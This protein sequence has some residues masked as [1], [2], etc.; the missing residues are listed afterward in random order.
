M[1]LSMQKMVVEGDK[2]PRGYGIAWVDHLTYRIICLPF[3]VN[4]IARRIRAW[5]HRVRNVYITDGEKALMEARRIRKRTD[6]DIANMFDI[7]S[8]KVYAVAFK[9]GQESS[10]DQLSKL[11]IEGRT[12]DERRRLQKAEGGEMAE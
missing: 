8:N 11:I 9:D 4:H 3:P 12:E 6:R 5:W 2:L 7:V 10:W 1:K